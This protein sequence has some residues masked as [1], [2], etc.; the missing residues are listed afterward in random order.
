MKYYPKL[1]PLTMDIY[2]NE[3]LPGDFIN[4]VEEDE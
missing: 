2:E 3:P 1:Y 4:P